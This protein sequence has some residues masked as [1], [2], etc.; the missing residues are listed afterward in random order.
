MK[1]KRVPWPRNM[2]EVYLDSAFEEVQVEIQ[3]C[4][5]GV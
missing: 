5:L 3:P 2:L 1:L 4:V